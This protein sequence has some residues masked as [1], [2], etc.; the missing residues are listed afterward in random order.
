[1]EPL[2]LASTVEPL[3]RITPSQSVNE[4]HGDS[5][6][7][8]SAC[9]AAPP[10]PHP[11]PLHTH[12]HSFTPLFTRMHTHS[13]EDCDKHIYSWTHDKKLYKHVYTRVCICTHRL[14]H[15]YNNYHIHTC[16][17]IHTCTGAHRA[18]SMSSWYNTMVKVYNQTL[19]HGS[20]HAS[21]YRLLL[22]KSIQGKN[23]EVLW[24]QSVHWQTCAMQ[25]S[26][27]SRTKNM[28]WQRTNVGTVI[29]KFLI[30]HPTRHIVG[31][32]WSMHSTQ[33]WRSS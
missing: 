9:S 29:S 19:Q 31:W 14:L 15:M 5:K 16:N 22:G 20:L 26:L 2:R 12:T 13:H 28:C 17:H 10:F 6:I 23:Q 32:I 21:P 11:L 4:V 3:R 27:G 30:L 8:T 25:L 24:R 18:C 33:N 7:Y 1:M